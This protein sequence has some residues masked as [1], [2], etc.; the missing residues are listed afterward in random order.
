MVCDT[1]V[2]AT[3]ECL[4][5]KSGVP[6]AASQGTWSSVG[7]ELPHC[8][9][10]GAFVS[11]STGVCNN[12]ARCGQYGNR[13]REPM[14]W[15]PENVRFTMDKE[16][17]G[18]PVTIQGPAQQTQSAGAQPQVQAQQ[19]QQ[20][21][22][23]PV[24][25]QAPVQSTG[26]QSV[27]PQGG[28]VPDVSVA[29]MQAAQ[30]PVNPQMQAF[31][32]MQQEAQSGNPVQLEPLNGG[33]TLDEKRQEVESRLQE[34]IDNFGA[35]ALDEDGNAKGRYLT[36]YGLVQEYQ[37]AK[38]EL[39][40]LEAA[41]SEDQFI[42]LGG[43]DLDI[44]Q[45][46]D[47]VDLTKKDYWGVYEYGD[48]TKNGTQQMLPCSRLYY[49]VGRRWGA[50]SG[51]AAKRGRKSNAATTAGSIA[52]IAVDML[53][54]NLS[55]ETVVEQDG[56]VLWHGDTFNGPHS[57]AKCPNC[58][59]FVS[60]GKPCKHCGNSGGFAAV[61]DRETNESACFVQGCPGVVNGEPCPHQMGVRLAASLLDG[62]S[63]EYRSQFS[64]A[65]YKLEQSKGTAREMSAVHAADAAYVLMKEVWADE[66]MTFG[67]KG[68]AERAG[69]VFGPLTKSV[70]SEE[71][72]KSVTERIREALGDP[73][74]P[75]PSYSKK[76]PAKHS[77]YF[78]MT[79]QVRDTMQMIGGAL[80]FGYS[81]NVRGME[82][83]SLGFYGPP[84]TGKNEML[85][86][87]AATM[88]LPYREIDLGRGSDLQALIGEVVLEPDGRG[89]TRS[90]AKLGP[91]GK[92]L[93]QGEV[94]ALNEIIHTDPDSQTL[95][96][97][98]TQEG[99]IQLHNPEGADQVYDVHPA[100]ILGVT[101]NPK[102]GMQD[103]PSEA[104]YSRLQS[105]RVGYPEAKEEQRRLAGW[106][107]GMGLPNVDERSV[108]RTI[109]FVNDLRE[110]SVR[111]GLDVPPTFRDAQRFV[112]QWKLTGNIDQGLEQMRGLASQ[113]D[114]H[115]LQWGEVTNLFERSFGDLVA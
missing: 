94:V 31:A 66:P 5:Q 81:P 92:A 75:V 35:Q 110:L 41:G 95:L 46:E 4:A 102:G 85:R 88:E 103:R 71:E 101:W 53:A 91:L 18:Q 115:D 39:D 76:E 10:C 23:Q 111:G 97:Q 62:E 28:A 14:G 44:D 37:D 57:P 13:V 87:A 109:T 50:G 82:G 12:R 30:P 2:H 84:G 22:A 61:Y 54:H 108:E 8:P 90:V 72:E 40:E 89:G 77:S 15:P 3:G 32:Q 16:K 67:A 104:L 17:W 107:E 98:I 55:E 78:V 114:D 106:A 60:P 73:K 9:F 65:L 11:P 86:E 93:T 45:P 100:S 25:P 63:G 56:L 105:R 59:K 21:G 64:S 34:V 33:S 83:R 80:R 70:G 74:P 42:D 49:D 19:A 7:A 1:G 96:H 27:Q 112:T 58:G 43:I 51:V 99:K 36:R 26:P 113:L 24:Q 79:D 48:G 68:A 52:P 47:G 20:A 6:T 38:N 69:Q 29:A